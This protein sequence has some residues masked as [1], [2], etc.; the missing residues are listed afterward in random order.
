MTENLVP[1]FHVEEVGRGP[2]PIEGAPTAT[3]ALLGMTGRGPS[4][5]RLVTS[6]AEY[7]RLYGTVGRFLPDAVRGFFANGG[8]RVFIARLTRARG[9]SRALAALEEEAE[10]GSVAAPGVTDP[11][12]LAA[13]LAHCEAHRRFAVLDGPRAAGADFDARPIGGSRNAA[14]YVPWLVVQRQTA[15]ERA[16]P[17][18]GHVLGVYARVD[19]ARGVWKA[20]AA[21]ALEGVLR[22]DFAVD[23]SRQAGR[24]AH[25]VNS[26]RRFEGRGIL[27]WGARTLST[28]AEWKYVSV[29]RLFLYLERSIDQ[30]MQWVVFE[31]NGASLWLKVRGQI[32]NFLTELW[33]AGAFPAARPDQAF[34]GRCDES[35]MTQ[36]DLHA[37]RLIV[38]I[39]FA[40]LRPAEF[41]VFR[42]GQWTCE[43]CR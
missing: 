32:D 42:I 41:V 34:Y 14:V 5:P 26:I 3:A 21:E 40:P 4:A 25:G 13:I 15:R 37:G 9:L 20:P 23:E 29:R 36:A 30:G 31:P 24:A 19:E 38:E 1:G 35:T 8:A 18:S 16:V 7:E 33:R 22:P 28:D 10:I 27:L 2:P 17:S 6:M 11:A 39:G 12:S 43:A